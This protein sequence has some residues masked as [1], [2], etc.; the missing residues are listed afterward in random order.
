MLK[1]YSADV[2]KVLAGKSS[3]TELRVL[4]SLT[5]QSCIQII[6]HAGGDPAGVLQHRSPDVAWGAA[7]GSAFT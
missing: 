6:P 5:G 7:R 3:M 1:L 4:E 2:Q